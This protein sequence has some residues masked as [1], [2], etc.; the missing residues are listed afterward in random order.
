MANNEIINLKKY[1][2]F[3][4]TNMIHR[5]SWQYLFYAW[6]KFEIN[7]GIAIISLW[8]SEMI[9]KTVYFNFGCDRCAN[10]SEALPLVDLLQRGFPKNFQTNYTMNFLNTAIHSRHNLY[11]IHTAKVQQAETQYSFEF[12]SCGTGRNLFP[13]QKM[14]HQIPV[15][16][17]PFRKL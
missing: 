3:S 11:S 4:W 5:D 2:N 16:F 10:L 8:L 1:G 9:Q 15:P 12:T 7:T 17:H 14:I 6:E 13:F